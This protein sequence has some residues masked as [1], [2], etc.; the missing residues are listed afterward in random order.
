MDNLNPP[1]V[2]IESNVIGL[3]QSL[4]IDEFFSVTDR[5]IDSTLTK[6]QFR[7]DSVG[8]GSFMLGGQVLAANEFHEI[9][10]SQIGS[11]TY[12]GATTFDSSSISVRVFDGLFWSNTASG[13]ITSGNSRPEL[14]VRD[15]RVA[16]SGSL[17]IASLLNY[18]DADGNPDRLYLVVDRKIG[19]N[20]GR[21]VLNDTV[22]PEG[23]WLAVPA[24]DLP[25]LVYEGASVQGES[26]RLSIRVF[27]GFSWSQEQDF[28]ISSSAPPQVIEGGPQEVL[29]SERRAASD[30]FS[31]VDVDQDS[32]VS[33]L[34][35]DRFRN[36]NGGFWELNGVRQASAEWFS[37]PANQLDNLFYVGGDV[38]PQTEDIGI[39]AF[40][41]FEFSAIGEVQVNTIARPMLTASNRTVNAGHFLNFETGGSA[42]TSGTVPAGDPIFDFL[43][44]SGA[45]IREFFF[46]D[47]SVNGGNFVFRGS[48]V[49]SATWFRVPAD[50]LDQLEYTG[51]QTGPISEQIGVMVN[52]NSVWND[53]GEFT[54]D[55]IRNSAAPVLQ[56]VDATARFGATI[57]LAA[58]F[59]WSD[60]DGDALQ[61]FRF[62]DT[63]PAAN[64]GFFTVNGVRQAA[65]TSI[66]LPFDQLDTVQYT[67]SSQISSE[68]IR[69]V[70][71]DGV[72]DSAVGT[73]TLSSLGLPSIEATENDI[74]V[75]TIERVAASSIINQT[76]SG[77]TL[78]RFQLFDENTQ[79]RSGRM[80]LDG[81][82]LQQGVIH[83]LTAAE[84]DRLVFKGA[85]VD[86]G[87]QLDPILIRGNNGSTGWTEWERVNVNTDPVANRSLESGFFIADKDNNPE[88]TFIT[89]S[90]IDGGSQDFGTFG[91][92]ANPAT[93]PLPSYYLLPDGTGR[94]EANATVA[95]SQEQRE[96]YRTVFEFYERVTDIDFVEVEYTLDAADAEVVIGAF[97]QNSPGTL[98][99]AFLP[100]TG[101][102]NGNLFSDIWFNSTTADFDPATPTDTSN[103]STFVA[104]AYH[105]LGHA[106][107]LKH[108]FEGEPFLSVF[109]NFN[110][111]TIMSNN[112]GGAQNPF[113]TYPGNQ[114]VASL[115]LYDIME[116]QR[117]YGANE[118][119]NDGD[120][121]YG[122]A[123]SGSDPHFSLNTDRNEDG[124]FIFNTEQSQTAIWDAGGID[125]FNYTFHVADETIDLRQGTWSS[126]NGVQQTL[127][128]TYG[129]IIENARGGSGNDN[130]RGNETRNFLFGNE[131]ND[132]L[133][134]GGDDDVLRGGIGDDTYV[135][136]LGDGRDFVQELAEGGVDSL[137]VF[138]PSGSINSLEDDLSFR[139]F[140]NELRIDFTLN[141]GESQGTV[142]INDFAVT[143]SRVELL[144]IHDGAGMQ[145]GE[146]IDL[147]SIFN[148]ANSLHQRFEL[149]GV[150][151]NTVPLGDDGVNRNGF[152]ASPV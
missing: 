126:V 61:S 40:D 46:V 69:L 109:T 119:W 58:L 18:S 51:Q 3:N 100:T 38:A 133:R 19:A 115:M 28:F 45:T 114:E 82:D 101:D 26:E 110:Y 113:P 132:V 106:V 111:N 48:D 32:I 9:P 122:N 151:A 108:P 12:R 127:N 103:G 25:D 21:L 68:E 76:D 33:Y 7:D 85:E 44:D 60:V 93:P 134:G 17:N 141:Q 147:Q 52:A 15:G 4:R 50:E 53:L 29:A 74:T 37:V 75:N 70:V 150:Q 83:D 2:L 43:D 79:F 130:I 112:R 67:F 23:Q 39:I 89:Y 88:K 102:G 98:G 16:T 11:V 95:M 59:D 145:V 128:I 152:I 139:R 84:F 47:R 131:G 66:S 123:F 10:F 34:F 30:M 140:G 20:G 55:T 107:G 149:T 5:D 78:S 86:F 146:S 57:P 87:R 125:T 41:G 64:S 92:V 120:N 8:G 97:D 118:E 143:D 117:L 6:I 42:N 148:Q 105:E 54:I 72:F 129:T 80:E 121:S 96:A 49:P 99:F 27:D 94:P 63:G 65:E 77:P 35:V 124:E 71:N 137:A 13:L 36:A 56:V 138:D 136:S 73:S 142:T 81:A 91:T 62:F 24:A 31:V 144:T 135:W 90:F 22:N 104:T 14:A 116:V 1:R